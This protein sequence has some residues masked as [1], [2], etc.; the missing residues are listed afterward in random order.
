MKSFLLVLVALFM[1]I[2][3][4]PWGFLYG[5]TWTPLAGGATWLKNCAISVNQSG[6]VFCAYLFNDLFLKNP[7]AV[8][9]FGDPNLTVSHILGKNKA[10]DNLRLPGRWLVCLL[11]FIDP[12]HVED[13]AN[14]PQ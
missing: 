9:A 1:W 8:L 4:A 12:N 10:Q 6:Q 13:A 5:L 14:N 3:L 11:H 7:K 2:L